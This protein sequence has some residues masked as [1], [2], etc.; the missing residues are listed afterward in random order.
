MIKNDL[1][2]EVY[3]KHTLDI[4]P[5]STDKPLTDPQQKEKKSKQNE[6]VS[7]DPNQSLPMFYHHKIKSKKFELF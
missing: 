1:A 5:F 2:I 3:D 6:N 7:T 4:I